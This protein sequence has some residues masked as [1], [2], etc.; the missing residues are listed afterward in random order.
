M[1]YQLSTIAQQCFL[2]QLLYQLLR[3]ARLTAV[4]GGAIGVVLAIL[5][6]LIVKGVEGVVQDPVRNNAAL[7]PLVYLPTII[8]SA[9]A[10]LFLR[11]ASRPLPRLWPRRATPEGAP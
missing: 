4:A 1:A 10:A 7:W 11:Y 2:S 3:M 6:M 5:L 9:V 8:G